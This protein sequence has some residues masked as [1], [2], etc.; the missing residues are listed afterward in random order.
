ML[1]KI[2]G[3]ARYSAKAIWAAIVPIAV[4]LA[5]NIGGELQAATQAA[6]TAVVG[7]VIVWLQ[8]NGPKP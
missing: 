1:S 2:I 5:E 8:A 4:E 3:Y 7:A 6:V